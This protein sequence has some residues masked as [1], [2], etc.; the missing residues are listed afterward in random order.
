[1][2]RLGRGLA[3]T[4]PLFVPARRGSIAAL[5]CVALLLAA[6]SND[7]P[8]ATADD[9]PPVDDEEEAASPDEEPAEPVPDEPDGAIATIEPPL[10]LAGT[11]WVPAN[12]SYQPGD[13][14]I[15]NPIGDGVFFEFGDDGTFFGSTGCNEFEGTWE[16]TGPYYDYDEAAEAFEDKHDGQPVMITAERTTAV[17][18]EGFLADDDVNLLGA[19]VAV[20][21][22]WIGNDLGDQERGIMLDGEGA[23]IWA[24]PA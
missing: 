21:I 22:W 19:L 17:E 8:P 9:P 18:C 14:G 7:D 10:D 13:T 16:I 2:P 15:T 4:R 23:R 24:D 20:E 12:F 5:V 1:M 11:S 6:C 3:V